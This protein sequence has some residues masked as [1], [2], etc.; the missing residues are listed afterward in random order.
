MS[1]DH[2][3]RASR[4]ALTVTAIAGAAVLVWLLFRNRGNG[5]DRSIG[6]KRGLKD[7]PSLVAQRRLVV[8][9]RSGDR[10]EVDGIDADLATALVLARDAGSVE[11]HTTGDARAG[12]VSKVYEALVEARVDVW[13]GPEVGDVRVLQSVS[14]RRA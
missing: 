14:P 5:M 7:I 10:V 13:A 2:D 11:F 9:T 4:T 8:R 3:D 1:R 6:A 12:W